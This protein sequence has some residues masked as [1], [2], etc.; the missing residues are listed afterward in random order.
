MG[1]LAWVRSKSFV[2]KLLPGYCK[3]SK[4][5]YTRWKLVVVR[6]CIYIF[7]TSKG[8]TVFLDYWKYSIT[9]SFLVRIAQYFLGIHILNK[10]LLKFQKCEKKINKSCQIWPGVVGEQIP[11]ELWPNSS[12]TIVNS[13]KPI[14]Q[15]RS[16]EWWDGLSISSWLYLP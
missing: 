10:N 9:L 6:W 1:D 4:I 7:I 15:Y 14:I 5:N 16:C 12:Q 13:Q 8:E 11:C 2:N 3:F